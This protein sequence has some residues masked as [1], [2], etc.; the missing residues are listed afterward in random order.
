MYVDFW[1]DYDLLFVFY[2]YLYVNYCNHYMHISHKSEF[3]AFYVEGINTF[4]LLSK[5]R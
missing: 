1:N 3:L 5:P 2:I 4:L